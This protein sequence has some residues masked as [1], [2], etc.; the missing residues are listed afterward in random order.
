MEN[1]EIRLREIKISDKWVL[2]KWI[3]DPDIIKYTSY[4]KP[5][6]DMEQDAWFNNIAYF[7][8]NFVFGIEY[9]PESKLIGTC[10]LY[11]FDSIAH[12]A[13]LRIKIG[14]NSYRG[15]GFA[16]QAM[17]YLLKFGFDDMNLNKIWLRVLTTNEPAV[18]LYS[19]TGFVKEGIS[20]QDMYIKGKYEDVLHMSIIKNE[21]YK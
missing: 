5:V 1:K 11:D 10:G 21:F 16:Q 9:M 19:K 12:K 17:D 2:H 20:R 7:K 14:D 4:Y 18:K 8:N 6:S 15:K 13:E 3:N